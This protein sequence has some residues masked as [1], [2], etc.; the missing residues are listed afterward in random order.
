MNITFYKM[1]NDCSKYNSPSLQQDKV[2]ASPG[3]TPV[4][5]DRLTINSSRLPTDEAS[6]ARILAREAAIHLE[7]GP[8]S[9][10]LLRLKQQVSDGTYVPDAR[11]IAQHMLGYRS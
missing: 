4:N 3:S 2:K 5:H 8:G 6:F 1:N 7:D 10:Q 9:E 11:R